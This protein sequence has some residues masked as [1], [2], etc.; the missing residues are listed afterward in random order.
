MANLETEAATAL[1]WLQYSALRHFRNSL[2]FDLLTKLAG[3]RMRVVV[4]AAPQM[5]QNVC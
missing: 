5:S 3:M 2:T 1:L 4:Y